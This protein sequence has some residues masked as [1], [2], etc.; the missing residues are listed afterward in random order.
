VMP[1]RIGT[2]VNHVLT[3]MTI[4]TD[5]SSDQSKGMSIDARLS[6]LDNVS[7]FT[8]QHK[9]KQQCSPGCSEA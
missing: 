1:T 9:S 3:R 7:S 8:P 5:I 4:D 6:Q 2:S